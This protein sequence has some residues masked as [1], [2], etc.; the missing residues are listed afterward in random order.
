MINGFIK[1]SIQILGNTYSYLPRDVQVE[2][3]ILGED[4]L[5]KFSVAIPI[6]MY[7]ADFMG[8]QGD[9]EMFSK[10]GLEIRNSY[11]LVVSQERWETEVK[12][13]FDDN[14]A[15]GDAT[16][17]ISN[18]IRPREGDLIYDPITKFL[19]EIKFVDHD[20]EFFALGKNYKYYLSCEAFRYQNEVIDT[21]DAEID[22]FNLNS[23]DLLLNQIILENGNIL[24]YEQGGYSLLEDGKYNMLNWQLLLENED[25]ITYEQEGYSILEHGIVEIQ[26][27]DYGVEF[28]TPATAINVT[29]VNPFA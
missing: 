17:N 9:R 16:F 13:Q 5:S 27:R 18:Y 2:D 4:V 28:S 21:G 24:K 11:K 20:V 19:F 1:E 10:F 14:L 12:T 23:T 6:E 7:L 3:L 29:V 15:N 8:F 25:F 26:M 22:L